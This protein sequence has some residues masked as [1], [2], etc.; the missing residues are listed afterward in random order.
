M[1]EPSTSKQPGSEPSI[2]ASPLVRTMMFTSLLSAGAAVGAVIAIDALTGGE[3][4]RVAM[5]EARRSVA[6]KKGVD[7]TAVGS[8]NKVVIDPCTGKTK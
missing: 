3:A 6:A 2:L 5:A 4:G 8:I 7:M 1:L